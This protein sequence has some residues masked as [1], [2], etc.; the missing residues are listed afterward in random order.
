M[1]GSFR[2]ESLTQHLKFSIYSP[3]ERKGEESMGER[4]REC[5]QASHCD[6]KSIKIHH[7][8][9]PDTVIQSGHIQSSKVGIFPTEPLRHPHNFLLECW[10]EGIP[11]CDLYLLLYLNFKG[12]SESD[13]LES[14]YFESETSL[15][16][17]KSG[18]K[19]QVELEFSDQHFANFRILDAAEMQDN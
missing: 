10:N 16:Q 4:W 8:P 5:M 12:N 2:N 9:L 7:Y 1:E 13:P 3:K 6:D 18:E 15:L 17:G 14:I 19:E 11:V